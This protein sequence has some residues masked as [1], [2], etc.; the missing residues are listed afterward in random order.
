MTHPTR[1]QLTLSLSPLFPNLL[2][3]GEARISGC[4]I[5]RW[6]VLMGGQDCYGVVGAGVDG[7]AVVQPELAAFVGSG[8][9][10]PVPR[11]RGRLCRM[12]LEIVVARRWRPAVAIHRSPPGRRSRLATGSAALEDAPASP[13]K[14]PSIAR[15]CPL[16][17]PSRH[18]LAPAESAAME[19]A[20]SPPSTGSHRELP[21]PAAAVEEVLGEEDDGA[22]SVLRWCTR[23]CVPAVELL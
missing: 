2:L 5:V 17:P 7:V 14:K 18:H 1:P 12:P 21:Q 16:A 22:N 4:W 20:E 9:K 3:M 15:I 23:L 19:E 8:R 6:I 10:V 13:W 11:R